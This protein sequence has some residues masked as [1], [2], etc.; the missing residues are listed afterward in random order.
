M[1]GHRCAPASRGKSGRAIRLA[2]A[3]LFA[4]LTAGCNPYL[5]RRETIS[6][7]AGDAAAANRA[8]HT[9]D[10]WPAAA[11]RPDIETS[12]R[13]TVDVIERYEER[14]TGAAPGAA[15]PPPAVVAGRP[16]S[17]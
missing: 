11:A 8:I 4:C 1:P 12:G 13:R 9:I 10:P 16:P 17:T 15:P 2:A 3:A 14:R 7:H 6:F 5:E